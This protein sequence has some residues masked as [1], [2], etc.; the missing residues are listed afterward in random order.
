M[1]CKYVLNLYSKREYISATS[2]DSGRSGDKGKHPFLLSSVLPCPISIVTP[3]WDIGI[4]SLRINLIL[5][6]SAGGT[7][8]L[9]YNNNYPL[10]LELVPWLILC[11]ILKSE[12]R[13]QYY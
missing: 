10:F 3:N 5:W 9:K 7:R 4:V 2:C 13:V 1:L 11:P 12:L 8:D 6:I